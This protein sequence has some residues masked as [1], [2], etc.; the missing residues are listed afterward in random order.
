LALAHTLAYGAT[1]MGDYSL[2]T[3]RLASADS[4]DRW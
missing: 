3:E 2:P 4:G 1:I